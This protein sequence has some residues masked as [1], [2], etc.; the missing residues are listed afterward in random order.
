MAGLTTTGFEIKRLADIKAEIEDTLRAQFGNQINLLPESVFG[1]L[2][3]IF[4]EREALLWELAEAVYNS[5]YPDRASGASLDDVVALTG[6]SRQPAVASVQE[7]LRLFGT[8]GTIVPAGTIISVSGTPSS[9]FATNN[10][11]VLAAGQDEEQLIEFSNVPDAGTWRLNWRGQDTITF[12]FNDNAAAIE[13]ALNDLPFGEGIEVSGNYSIGFTVSFAGNAGKQEQP[14]IV[15]DLNA[16]TES[17]NPVGITISTTTQGVNQAIVNATC[18]ETGPVVAPAG[19]LTEIET[20]V[21]GLDRVINVTDA[22][23]GRDLETDN[24]LRARR[25]D[26]LQLAGAATVDAIRSRLLNVEGVSAVIIFENITDV[27]D[28]DGRPP[29]SYE[30]VV[31]GGDDQEIGDEIWASKPVGIQTVGDIPVVT[32]DLAGNSQTVNFSRPTEVDIYLEVDL[33]T[34]AEFPT[35]GVSQVRE[36]LL[37]YFSTFE[38]GQDVIVYPKLVCAIDP[39]PGIIDIAIRIGTAPAPT[40]DSNITINSNQVAVLESGNL[41]VTEL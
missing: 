5:R 18:E 29:H 21:S 40:L 25:V 33:T 9:R 31:Q 39:V 4:S 10:D 35:D 1:Q 34:D 20:P 37:E 13:A 26:T 16:L 2:V 30:A 11:A 8:A 27:T 24:E 36:A 28:I 23:V 14:E 15:V 7:D 22:E 41:T 38:I 19:T 3:G 32:Q 12:N 6:I 17:S